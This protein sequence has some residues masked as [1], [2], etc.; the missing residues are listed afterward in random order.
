[1]LTRFQESAI[2]ASRKLRQN[3]RDSK[4]EAFCGKMTEDDKDK[5]I[6]A[7]KISKVSLPQYQMPL[8]AG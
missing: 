1:M 6:N 8:F 2:S 7:S 3:R 4:F 5:M